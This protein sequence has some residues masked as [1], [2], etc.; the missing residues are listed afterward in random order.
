MVK[1][2]DDILPEEKC[3][4][5]IKLFE[6]NFEY[7][8]YLNHDY[9]PCFN[10]LNLNVY[11][12]HMIPTLVDYTKRLYKRY[13]DDVGNPFI[14]RMQYL[15]EF[16]L[17]RY[18]TSGEQ[19]FDE[20]VDVDNHNTAKR[21]VAFIYYLNDNDGETQFTFSGERIEPKTGRAVVFPPTWEYPH[22]GLPPTDN[23]KY[24]L[25]TYIHYG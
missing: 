7:H 9:K 19:R 18:D 23:T 8:E 24:I 11:C 16:R 21:A 3:K 6:K 12:S 5:L 22:A 10:Q 2:Y 25:S 17:K 1:V 14:P 13:K 20:H 15:E 4:N